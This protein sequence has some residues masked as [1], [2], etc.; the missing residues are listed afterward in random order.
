[1]LSQP[2]FDILIIN[3]YPLELPVSFIQKLTCLTIVVNVCVGGQYVAQLLAKG[4]MEQE[5]GRLTR[6]GSRPEM[7]G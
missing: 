4:L 6:T 7:K 1:M 5:K 3:H 2:D